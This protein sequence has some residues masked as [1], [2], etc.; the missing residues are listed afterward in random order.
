LEGNHILDFARQGGVYR[1]PEG[2][3]YR[4]MTTDF[5]DPR[6]RAQYH[7]PPRSLEDCGHVMRCSERSLASRARDVAQ[8]LFPRRAGAWL[9][10]SGF[11]GA[12]AGRSAAARRF[13]R[14]VRTW[15]P[16]VQRR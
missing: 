1:T 3:H 4:N 6:V 14:R 8:F 16:D 13:Y 10:R 9:G 11:G 5:D 15:L 7:F 12:A 2:F